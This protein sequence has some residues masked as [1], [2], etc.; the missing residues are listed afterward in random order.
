MTYFKNISTIDELKKAYRKLCQINHPDNGGHV[1]TMA[2][3]N[4]EYAE[5]FNALKNAHN[6]KA[7]ADE[8]G[9]TKP[10]NECPEE[11]INI[12]TELLKI[13]GLNIELCGSW[14]WIS[15]ETKVN[16]ETLKA[17][18]CRWA[19]KKL[20][21]YWR[22]E[23]DAVRSRGAKSMDYIRTKYGSESYSTSELYIA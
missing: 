12:I 10:I 17:L 1:E 15:G 20:M 6:A 22:N 23:K 5:A 18:G 11:F 21:W 8:T 4:T 2:Q 3:I 16:K 13:K 14:I 19:S 7:A 9:R